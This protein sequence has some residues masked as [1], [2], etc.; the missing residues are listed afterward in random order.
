MSVDDLTA[1]LGQRRSPRRSVIRIPPSYVIVGALAVFLGIFVLWAVIGDDLLGGEPVAVAAAHLPAGAAAKPPGPQA[2]EGNGG[3][4][5][6]DGP[7]QASPPNPLPKVEHGTD[8][9]AN[10]TRTVNIIN[11]ATGARQEVTIPAPAP[12]G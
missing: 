9:T 3:V 10:G 4:G 6:Y 5:R 7:A 2:A 12:G 8:E 11:G 1:P